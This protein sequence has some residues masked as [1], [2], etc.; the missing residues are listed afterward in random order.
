MQ[1]PPSVAAESA[2]PPAD[3][4]TGMSAVVLQD[5]TESGTT[6]KTETSTTC[7]VDQ[8]QQVNQPR[9]ITSAIEAENPIAGEQ[10]LVQLAQ[11]I[12]VSKME[13]YCR[14]LHYRAV[15]LSSV[16]YTP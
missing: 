4:I 5:N 13:L 16:G 8:G 9:Q 6:S 2:M 10:T 1:G 3:D 11:F 7:E 15:A 12:I 14:K